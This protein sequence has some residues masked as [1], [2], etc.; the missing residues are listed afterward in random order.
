[1]GVRINFDFFIIFFVEFSKA[2]VKFFAR[3]LRL[4]KI[5]NPRS[6]RVAEGPKD[7]VSSSARHRSTWDEGT[8]CS[9]IIRELALT[10][11][12][13]FRYCFEW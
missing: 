8:S 12:F 4:N 3:G 6:H 11:G 9:V 13:L 7:A 5:D 1:M 2:N 10:L